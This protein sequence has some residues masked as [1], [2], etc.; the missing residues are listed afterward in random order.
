MPSLP[1]GGADL[2]LE[3]RNTGYVKPL[4]MYKSLSFFGANVVITVRCRLVA[5]FGFR[6]VEVSHRRERR[7]GGIVASQR[8]RSQKCAHLPIIRKPSRPTTAQDNNA[9]VFEETLRVM[10]DWMQAVMPKSGDVHRD[11]E[12]TLTTMQMALMVRAIP[13][14]TQTLT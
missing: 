9:L 12:V 8:Q 4:Y 3:L 13:L 5:D 14:S 6:S 7:G 10:N 2:N 1:L 11:E